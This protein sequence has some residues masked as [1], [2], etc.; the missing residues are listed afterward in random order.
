MQFLTDL[1]GPL[2]P[3]YQFERTRHDT[4]I[5][6]DAVVNFIFVAIVVVVVV[7]VILFVVFFAV[8]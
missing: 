8:F 3:A 6:V 4:V 5:I 1:S 7:V 2:A